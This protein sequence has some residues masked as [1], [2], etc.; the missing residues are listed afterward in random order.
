MSEN[1]KCNPHELWRRFTEGD[2]EALSSIYFES[3]DMLLNFGMKYSSDRSFIE[4]CIQ[5]LFIDLLKKRHRQKEVLD[6]K[7]Y[8]LKA[9]RNQMLYSQR[10]TKRLTLM[11]E[12]EISRMDFRI[13][14]AIE[15]DLIL[16]DVNEMRAKFL[17]MVTETL[18]L[19][20]KEALYLKFNCG[21]NYIEISEL[22]QISVESARTIIY[23]TLKTL[24]N[25]FGKEDYYNLIF[26]IL[27][28]SF[29]NTSSN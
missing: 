16:K 15:N 12:T 21:L 22:M 23:R 3:F 28:R 25:T 19:R 4:D 11:P 6:V 1:I 17:K 27:H 2:N 8:L 14:Y 5:N 13:T 7:F 20:Q 9:L 10:K 18:T 26:F 24:K 29:W